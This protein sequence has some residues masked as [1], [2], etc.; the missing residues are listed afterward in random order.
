MSLFP[1][2]ANADN[3]FKSSFSTGG[4]ASTANP[5]PPNANAIPNSESVNVP[6]V[7]ET[8]EPE[9]NISNTNTT[10]T[11]STPA[12][13]NS[14]L[15]EKSAE[16][17]ALSPLQKK[18]ME[19]LQKKTEAKTIETPPILSPIEPSEQKTEPEK[20]EVK[21]PSSPNKDQLDQFERS[22]V[23]IAGF[24]V[25]EAQKFRSN[26]IPLNPEELNDI[27]EED[28]GKY[29]NL[30][31]TEKEEM[32]DL[33]DMY[34]EKF[35]SHENKAGGICLDELLELAI[36]KEA[37]DIHFSAGAKVALRIN[38][39]IHF[40]DN[41]PPLS[42]AQARNLIFSL[43]DNPL[44][45]RR[46]FEERELDC[47]YEHKNGVNFRVNIFFKQGRIAAVL[48]KIASQAMTM[49]QLGLP[50]AVQRLLKQ[51]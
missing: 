2:A 23:R 8:T 40:I 12:A 1:T 28:D 47:G 33:S 17:S 48:R 32:E 25:P 29:T 3:K 9:I 18:I 45:R 39:K 4:S 44:H 19:Q 36:D 7:S 6:P 34:L 22:S 13:I 5:V 24:N 15:P 16:A 42:S 31:D 26:F 46:I 21:K 30:S 14:A 11:L 27:I 20:V 50:D 43:V 51:K 37:S 38:G 10:E 49:D 41:L 35:L